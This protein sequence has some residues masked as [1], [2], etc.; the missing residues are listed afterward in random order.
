MAIVIS[1]R[2]GGGVGVAEPADFN[3]ASAMLLL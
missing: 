3:T 1:S 2:R